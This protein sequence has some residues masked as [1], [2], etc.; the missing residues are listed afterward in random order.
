MKRILKNYFIIGFVVFGFL[1]SADAESLFKN[2]SA[3]AKDVGKSAQKDINRLAFES[4]NI[5]TLGQLRKERERERLELET[6][7]ARERQNAAK[8]KREL[9][10]RQAK[11]ELTYMKEAEKVYMVIQENFQIGE[12]FATS[13]INNVRQT[14]KIYELEFIENN[15]RV[16]LAKTHLEDLEDWNQKWGDLY[17]NKSS[18]SSDDE[19]SL[20]EVRQNLTEKIQAYKKQTEN[21]SKFISTGKPVLSQ[22]S[23][24]NRELE[25]EELILSILEKEKEMILSLKKGRAVIESIKES[26]KKKIE[27]LKNKINNLEKKK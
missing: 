4:A 8:E 7:R 16:Q 2:P 5:L 11:M 18:S 25:F 21:L 9:L 19:K 12:S 6:Q 14:I 17:F 15:G 1:R 20:E 3:W 26:N 13:Y 27:N 23:L 22:E 24:E 10:L